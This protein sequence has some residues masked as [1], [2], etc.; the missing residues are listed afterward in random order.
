MSNNSLI[1]DDSKCDDPINDELDVF[2][3]QRIWI[4]F[5][6]QQTNTRMRNWSFNV[7][8]FRWS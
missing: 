7:R 2:L 5:K 1:N 3:G 4:L 6:F 8:K